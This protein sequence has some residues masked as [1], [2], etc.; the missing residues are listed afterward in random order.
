MLRFRRS[1][2]TVC[3]GLCM[4]VTILEQLRRKGGTEKLGP[5]AKSAPRTCQ[6]HCWRSSHPCRCPR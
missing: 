3:S 1:R 2:V 6:G 5:R 4:S